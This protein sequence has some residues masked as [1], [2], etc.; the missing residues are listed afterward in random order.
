MTG[1]PER[2]QAGK[3]DN[4]KTLRYPNITD[5]EAFFESVNY[6]P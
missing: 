6:F 1:P 2:L 5:A 3:A 4:D